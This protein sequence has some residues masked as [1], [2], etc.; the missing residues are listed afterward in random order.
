MDEGEEVRT[1]SESLSTR[2]AS[3]SNVPD[4]SWNGCQ[5]AFPADSFRSILTL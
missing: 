2:S 1:S 3:K 5:R 4:L